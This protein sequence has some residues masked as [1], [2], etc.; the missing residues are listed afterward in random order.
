MPEGKHWAPVDWGHVIADVVAGGGWKAGVELG[1]EDTSRP[2]A[3][4]IP[5]GEVD[6]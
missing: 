4:R 3:V 1:L 5:G 6:L 2:A